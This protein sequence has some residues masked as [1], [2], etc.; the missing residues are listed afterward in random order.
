MNSLNPIYLITKLEATNQSDESPEYWRL[1]AIHLQPQ[2]NNKQKGG[3]KK[4]IMT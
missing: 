3:D 1:S 4:K 2:D